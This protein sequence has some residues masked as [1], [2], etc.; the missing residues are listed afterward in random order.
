MKQEQAL[1]EHITNMPFGC[2]DL[3][4]ADVAGSKPSAFCRHNLTMRE[5]C[6]GVERASL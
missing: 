5:M 1:R 3:T 2:A 4:T 6:A